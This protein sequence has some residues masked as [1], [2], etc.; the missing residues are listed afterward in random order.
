MEGSAPAVGFAA[1]KRPLPLPA[2]GDVGWLLIAVLAAAGAGLLAVT[3]ERLAVDLALIAIAAVA[4]YCYPF[5]ALLAVLVVAPKHSPFVELLFLCAAGAVAIWRLPR[6]PG[7]E[8]LLPLAAFLLFAL[9]GVDWHSGFFP[10]GTGRELWIPGAHYAYLDTPTVEGFEWLRLAFVMVVALLAATEVTSLSR[11]RAVVVAS[12]LAAVYPILT[13]VKQLVTGELV[14]KGDFSAVRGSFNFPNEFG[15]YLVLFLLLATVALFELRSRWLKLLTA[16]LAAPALLML[17]H[18]YTRS[19]WIGFALGLVILALLQYRSLIAVALL[20]LVV[21]IVGFPS[22]VKDV[23]A[24]FGDLASQNAANS[25]NSLTW[26]RGQWSAMAH[27]GW[28]K[29]LTGQGFGSYR[30][31]TVEQFGLEGKTYGTVQ[32][33]EQNGTTTRGFTAHNDFVK[34]WVE[35][36]AIGLFL[37]IAVLVGLAVVQIRAM[38][39]RAMAPWATALL[40]AT[41]AFAVMSASD[42]VQGYTVPVVYLFVLTG[43]AA[44]A[45]KALRMSPASRDSS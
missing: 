39:A 38:R 27:F 25:K 6:A 13:G 45:A 20:V 23:Q 3:H 22:A 43:A 14:S 36:G 31:K 29:P 9:P 32:D 35:T 11:F 28:D 44:G 30:R 18:S 10:G 21:A 17:L 37:W 5:P 16:L 1:R 4:I 40:G 26:R 24:R 8:L 2:L 34:S 15:V 33:T 12:L 41:L 19:A 7:R 42:N